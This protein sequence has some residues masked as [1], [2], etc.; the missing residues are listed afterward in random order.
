MDIL[1]AFWRRLCLLHLPRRE[2]HTR[3]CNK[4]RRLVRPDCW[5]SD[6]RNGIVLHPCAPFGVS[7]AAAD[8]L[9]VKHWRWGCS[10]LL[11]AITIL[12][13]ICKIFLWLCAEVCCSRRLECICCLEHYT[14]FRTRQSCDVFAVLFILDSSWILPSI[15]VVSSPPQTH[16]NNEQMLFRLHFKS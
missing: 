10:C 15:G 5:L 1:L 7:G 2:K 6:C 3:I 11:W 14:L 13:K 4:P 8:W 12:A 16:R 9:L